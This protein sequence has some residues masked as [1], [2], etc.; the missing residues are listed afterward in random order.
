MKIRKIRRRRSRSSSYYT[1]NLVFSRSCFAE[2][3]KEMYKDLYRICTAIGLLIKAFVCRRSHC[4]R[5]QIFCDPLMTGFT[6][7]HCVDYK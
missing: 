5:D 1:Q 7:F 4:R 2:D 3:D 6:G